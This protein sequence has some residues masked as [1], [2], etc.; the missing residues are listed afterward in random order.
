MA[1]DM[2]AAGLC[3]SADAHRLELS[4]YDL[5]VDYDVKRKA[6]VCKKL[7]NFRKDMIIT[8]LML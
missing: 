5:A 3:S 6:L 4:E 7:I 1:Q 2:I 8:N